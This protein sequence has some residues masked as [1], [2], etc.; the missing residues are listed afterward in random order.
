MFIKYRHSIRHTAFLRVAAAN[1]TVFLLLCKILVPTAQAQTCT[2][3]NGSYVYSGSTYLGFFGS[4]SAFNSIMNSIGPYGST[5]GVNSV[6]NTFGSYGSS[7][8]STSAN[9]NYA[10]NPPVIY[11][12]GLALY[13]LTT[14]SFITPRVSLASIDAACGFTS[15]SAI[16]YP[17][18]APAAVSAADGTNTSGLDVG[19][20]AV[21]GA[22]SYNVYY[23]TTNSNYALLGNT[24]DLGT[25]ITGLDQGVTYYIA[26]KAV[27]SGGESLTYNYDTGYLATPISF[28]VTPSSGANGSIDPSTAV[29]VAENATTSFTVTADSGYEISSIGGTCGGT[30]SGSTYTTNAITGDCSVDATFTE[31]AGVSFTV[32]PSVFQGTG[33]EISPIDPQTVSAGDTAT[34]T[35]TPN[36]G[37]RV[38][39]VGG[40]CGGNFYPST[41]TF[42]TNPV[43]ADC[44]VSAGFYVS[45]DTY[46]VTVTGGP[47]GTV[48][49]S[50]VQEVSV[51][52]SLD[53]TL[54]PD[55]GYEIG[56]VGGTCGGEL[57]SSIYTTNAI[58][59]DC[60][61]TA[62]FS[63]GSVSPAAAFIERFYVNILGRPSDEGGMDN[64][65]NVINTQ[66]ASTVALGFLN[67]AEFKNK[68]LDDA[69]FV[70]ILYRTLFDREGDAGGTS[71]WLEQLAGGKLR[72]MVIW[73]F[74]RAAEFKTLSDSFG[75][76]ALNAAD[77]SAYG[78]RAFVERFYTLVL[79]RQPDKGGFDNW[80]TALTN[81]TYAGGD[82]AKA[83]FLSAEYLNQNTSDDAFVET[84]YKAFFGREADSAGKEG[85][86]NVLA[87]GQ[88]R[89]YV[90]DGFIG[91]AEFVALAN[92]YGI[93]AS[94]VASE[95]A[96][97]SRD[98][99]AELSA[100]EEAKPI[101]TLPMLGLFILGGLLGL[102]G[103]QRLAHR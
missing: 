57:S 48:A 99:E 93:S 45:L 8:S 2:E 32:T 35:L 11:K 78:I 56:S 25:T 92:S 96:R 65:L 46:T 62:T 72:D 28:T 53:I 16:A 31:T 43:T 14:N 86:L 30:L 101:P 102:L 47:N 80:V 79:G 19:W 71:Y 84:A 29:T 6:R 9:N 75:V 76:T 42:I 61:V 60:T 36:S 33:G 73:G 34:F 94:R 13:Y 20:T 64:W 37:Y 59:S 5:T 63:V 100:S 81:G 70:D 17:A 69:A 23:S 4:A 103:I 87:Q 67:S 58:T 98:A 91:S 89:E 90:L 83:F 26:V 38:S 95:S 24:S 74:L 52:R 97:M 41:L 10:S 55:P 22:T 66:S 3:L 82:I 85:W 49:P 50:G 21:A 88:S 7:Y 12:H 27:N 1:L 77:E 15:F 44:T 51:N 39:N 54:S 40:T 18:N 68:G